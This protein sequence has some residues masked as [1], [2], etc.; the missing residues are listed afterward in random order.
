MK[1][2]FFLLLP[3]FAFSQISVYGVGLTEV[4]SSTDLENS[5]SLRGTTVAV[6]AFV[7][8]E[9]A[10]HIGVSDDLF[11]LGV[12]NYIGKR[13]WA[14]VGCNFDYHRNRVSFNESWGLSLMGGLI[15][16]RGDFAE[17]MVLGSAG[18][19]NSYIRANIGIGARLKF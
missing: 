9:V 14:L 4:R 13:E 19:S 16:F 15:P 18:F 5:F 17:I 6:G 8:E 12:I 10:A 7:G 11:Q 1:V 2:L 3:I